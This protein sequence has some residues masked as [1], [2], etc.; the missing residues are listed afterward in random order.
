MLAYVPVHVGMQTNGDRRCDDY[1]ASQ[2][3]T[4]CASCS[5][6]RDT[7][8]NRDSTHIRRM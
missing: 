5:S 7:N 4:E 8:V 6:W 1:S 2:F 3:I